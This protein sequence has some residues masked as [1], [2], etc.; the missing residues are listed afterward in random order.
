[1]RQKLFLGGIGRIVTDDLFP[2]DLILADTVDPPSPF[3]PSPMND[4][5]STLS[6]VDV[7]NNDDDATLPPMTS[8]PRPT[9][10]DGILQT[11]GTGMEGIP[12]TQRQMADL[13]A[14]SL[15]V[16]E[17]YDIAFMHCATGSF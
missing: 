7:N 15:P 11:S 17:W 4:V 6:R 16:G 10:P 12:A 3:A 2:G 14:L 5:D 1:M 8:P 13:K 9:L